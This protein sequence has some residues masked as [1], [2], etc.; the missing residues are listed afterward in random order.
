MPQQ[1]VKRKSRIFAYAE[2]QRQRQ[3]LEQKIL[4]KNPDWARARREELRALKEKEDAD[5][6][7]EVKQED[8]DEGRVIKLHRILHP[9]PKNPS[10]YQDANGKWQDNPY[11]DLDPIDATQ[12]EWIDPTKIPRR[13]W[14]Y[15]PHYVRGFLSGTFSTGGVGK[16]S[17]TIAEALAMVTGKDLL[18][19]QPTDKLR[20]WYWNGE[21][22][23]DELQRRFAAVCLHYKICKQDI[24][25]R[26]FVD[27]GRTTP[28]VIAEDSR[29][30]AIIAKPVMGEVI[31]TIFNNKIDVLIIDP[32]VSIHRVSEND[33]SAV[34]RVAKTWAQIAEVANCAIAIAHHT[35]KISGSGE[36]TV[37]DG[38]GASA[39][40]AA[41]RTART[42]NTMSKSDSERL[43][44]PGRNRL[45]FFRAD[46]G[47][48][49]LTRPAESADWF[50]IQ[51]VRL[52]NEVGGGGD[53]VG[54]VAHW[55]IPE[56]VAPR[57]GAEGI[58]KIQQAL[59]VDG[60][61]RED[62]RSRGW[63]GEAYAEALGLDITRKAV[64]NAIARGLQALVKAGFLKRTTTRDHTRQIR[65]FIEAGAPVADDAVVL[66]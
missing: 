45:N 29:S 57:I 31:K 64:A 1:D 4:W 43:G 60:P 65:A 12:F 52:G 30:G 23:M 37:D 66:L 13:Q 61:W 53:E 10:K 24:G 20:V 7:S 18:G 51:S 3:D 6:A 11:V 9:L 56:D 35:R 42:L 34:E 5:R 46:I 21:D 63:A 32:F 2:T 44:I 33:N 40:L 25:D 48:A 50:N 54:V 17:L 15:R 26:L 16:S 22:P 58:R 47:K 19:V 28:I 36:A 62:R 41:I 39:L 59:K 38:R 49:N 27:S 55:D 14:L 8:T